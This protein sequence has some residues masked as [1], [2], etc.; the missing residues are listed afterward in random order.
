MRK[1]NPIRKSFFYYVN[2]AKWFYEMML[3]HTYCFSNAIFWNACICTVLA[4]FSSTSVKAGTSDG[5]FYAEKADLHFENNRFKEALEF[6]NQSALWYEKNGHFDSLAVLEVKIAKTHL[7]LGEYKKGIVLMEKLTVN[8]EL[9]HATAADAWFVLAECFFYLSEPWSALEAYHTSRNYYQLNE[10]VSSL[11]EA[12]LEMSI[13]NVYRYELYDFQAALKHYFNALNFIKNSDEERKNE[14]IF[15][16][17]YNIAGTYR[18]RQQPEQ[19][20]NYSDLLI[21][22]ANEKQSAQQLEYAYTLSANIAV[23]RKNHDQ[24][25]RLYKNIIDA[26]ED[27]QIKNENLYLTSMEN[28]ATV[29]MRIYQPDSALI[30]V[31]KARAFLKAEERTNYI[32]QSNLHELFAAIHESTGN[33]NLAM[34]EALQGLYVA[35]YHLGIG[36]PQRAKMQNML[37]RLSFD[38]EDYAGALDYCQK[39]L[40]TVSAGVSID[41]GYQNPELAALKADHL[42]FNILLTKGRALLHLAASEGSSDLLNVAQQTFLLADSIAERTLQTSLLES[43]KVLFA[44]ESMQLYE[45]ALQVAMHLW[46]M[47]K[48][49]DQLQIILHWMEK[50][51]SRVLQK[52][53]YEAQQLNRTGVPD[54]L[55]RRQFD[56]SRQ[57]NQLSHRGFIQDSLQQFRVNLLLQLEH[58]QQNIESQYSNYALFSQGLSTRQIHQLQQYTKAYICNGNLGLW[59]MGKSDT[60]RSGIYIQIACFHGESSCLAQNQ[61]SRI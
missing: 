36:H 16:C 9:Y 8:T 31:N 12:H 17:Y 41:P 42:N 18:S 45:P 55:I 54:S 15:W 47:Q 6:Y 40:E 28:I 27:G 44:T 50:N 37:A 46:K 23:V 33:H 5:S 1:G 20:A 4:L 39:A 57:I 2:K 3:F 60:S 53:I 30:W 51:K 61:R 11:R 34:Q 58:I 56:I 25:L 59:H 13:G 43:D 26:I 32:S 38:N 29:Y 7:L 19:A 14:M 21:T 52:A 35:N 48:N 22:M 24:A 10:K 49:E